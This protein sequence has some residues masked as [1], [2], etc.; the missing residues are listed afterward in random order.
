MSREVA[1]VEYR[2]A[3]DRPWFVWGVYDDIPT[4]R[5]RLAEVGMTVPVAPAQTQWRLHPWTW[6]NEYGGEYRA[7]KHRV[8]RRGES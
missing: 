2:P 8:T 3:P 7:R 1:V 4:A 5:D 6:T